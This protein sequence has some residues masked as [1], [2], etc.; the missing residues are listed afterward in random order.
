MKL[1]QQMLRKMVREAVESSRESYEDWN[2]GFERRAAERRW[3]SLSGKFP[4]QMQLVEAV[5]KGDLTPQQSEYIRKMADSPESKANYSE[6]QVV[7]DTYGYAQAFLNPKGSGGLLQDP[8][9]PRRVMEFSVWMNKLIDSGARQGLSSE[10]VLSDPRNQKTMQQM[11]QALKLKKYSDTDW[12]PPT[13]AQVGGTPAAPE[14]PKKSLE[15]IWG[16]P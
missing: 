1:T 5:T 6:Q 15:S 10:Q 7:K 12:R 11:L 13:A 16:A 8:S 14:A 2:A 4:T 3:R 9:G